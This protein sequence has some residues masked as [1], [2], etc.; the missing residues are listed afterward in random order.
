MSSIFSSP[1]L[2]DIRLIA[3]RMS[4]ECNTPAEKA[5]VERDLEVCLRCLA[6]TKAEMVAA[7]QRAAEAIGLTGEGGQLVSGHSGRIGGGPV[8]T[9]FS[10]VVGP[11]EGAFDNH[12]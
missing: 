1:S 4:F 2:C 11:G 3:A 9:L 8:W 12:V 7:F 5:T 6:M 10:V